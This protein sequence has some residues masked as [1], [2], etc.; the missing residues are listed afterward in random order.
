MNGLTLSITQLNTYIKRIFDA[1]EML[2]NIS[3]YGEVSNFKISNGIAY[4]DLKEEGAQISCVKFSCF[5]PVAKNGDKVLLTGRLNFHIKLGRLSF[6]ADKIEPYGMGDL[7]KK[8]LELKARLEAEGL[9]DASKKQPI[10]KYAT[11]IGVVTSETGAVIRDIYHV[12]KAKNPVVDLLVYPAKVQGTDAEKTIVQGIEYFNSRDDIDTIIVARGG[13]SFEDLSP[14]NTELVARAVFNSRL[15]IISGV[16][17]ETDFTIID[18]CA[19][20]RAPT[21]SVAADLAVY[22]Y[23]NELQ[24]IDDMRSRIYKAISNKVKSSQDDIISLNNQ[25]ASATNLCLVSAKNVVGSKIA[26]LTAKIDKIMQE[27]Q[28]VFEMVNLKIQKSNPLELLKRGY[29][30]IY[31]DSMLVNSISDVA[32]GQRIENTLKDGKI[33]SVVEKVEGK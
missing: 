9:F 19:D 20:L 12:T 23:Y 30:R 5:A 33:I 29:S 18:F 1:E 16:G 14:F 22:D 10:K 31:K 27:K 3:I 7:Y 13:G 25:I 26:L 8:F 4:F 21:P 24:Y 32:C 17:H 11:K 28:K 15:P 6:V 2:F